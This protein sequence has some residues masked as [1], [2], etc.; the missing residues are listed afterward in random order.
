MKPRAV[1]NGPDAKAIQTGVNLRWWTS[2]WGRGRG[3]RPAGIQSD[4][5]RR[6]W[7]RPAAMRVHRRPGFNT[8][9][10][11]RSLS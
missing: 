2:G 8:S 6:L 1:G 4:S 5:T 10:M 11:H 7:S 9:A 3:W